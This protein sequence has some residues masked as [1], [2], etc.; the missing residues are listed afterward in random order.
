MRSL[1]GLLLAAFLVAGGCAPE[2]PPPAP[3]GA[4]PAQLER[5]KIYVVTDQAG[6]GDGGFNDVCLAGVARARDELDIDYTLLHS[7]QRADFETNLVTGARKGKVVVSLGFLIA[8][9]VAQVAGQFP[10]TYFVHIEKR[11]LPTFPI[12]FWAI[13]KRVST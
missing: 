3:A 10:D 9:E 11:V 4:A 6:P 5:V 8:D 2:E 12:F 13:V 7:R 1:G